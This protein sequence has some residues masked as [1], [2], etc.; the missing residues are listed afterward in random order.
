[1]C[2]CVCADAGGVPEKKKKQCSKKYKEKKNRFFFLMNR[3][4]SENLAVASCLILSSEN[5]CWFKQM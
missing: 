1:M 2:V 3:F 5:E 4:T